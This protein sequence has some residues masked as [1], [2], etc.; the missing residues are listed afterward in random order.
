MPLRIFKVTKDQSLK[1]S[2]D[3]GS[4]GDDHAPVGKHQSQADVF[5]Q[6]WDFD[7]DWTGMTRLRGAWLVAK[8]TGEVHLAFGGSPRVVVSYLDAAFRTGGGAENSWSASAPE[9]YP[10]PARSGSAEDSVTTAQGKRVRVSIIGLMEAVAPASVKRRNGTPC[11]GARLFGLAVSSA[12]PTSSSRS[13]EFYG[14][15]AGAANRPYIEVEYDDNE[16]PRAPLAETL[17]PLTE[18]DAS[19][20]GYP[21]RTVETTGPL[22]VVHMELDDPDLP[23]PDPRPLVLPPGSAKTDHITRW[24]IEVYQA[25]ATDAT[26]DAGTAVR[27]AKATGSVS[28]TVTREVDPSMALDEDLMNV[29]VQWRG[30]LYDKRGEQGPWCPLQKVRLNRPPK[31]PTAVFADPGSQDPTVTGVLLDDDAGS[32]LA[33]TQSVRTTWS[34]RDPATGLVTVKE[35]RWHDTAGGTAFSVATSP[36]LDWDREYRLFVQVRDQFGSV[37]PA[38]GEPGAMPYTLVTPRQVLGPDDMTPRS[39]ATRLL[40]RTPTLTIGHSVAFDQHELLAYETVDERG[41]PTGAPSWTVPVTSNTSG[42]TVAKVWAGAARAWGQTFWWMAR[43]HITGGAWTPWSRAYPVY[44]DAMPSGS[45]VYH[46]QAD[47]TLRLVTEHVELVTETLR[48]QFVIPFTDPDIGDTPRWRR[49]EV[50]AALDNALILGSLVPLQARADVVDPCRLLAMEAYEGASGAVGG[51]TENPAAGEM[52]L[53]LDTARWEQGLASLRMALTAF[54]IST[55]AIAQSPPLTLGTLYTDLSSALITRFLVDVRITGYHAAGGPTVRLRWVFATS[56]DFVEYDI[57]PGSAPDFQT[58]TMMKADVATAAPYPVAIGGTVDWSKVTAVQLRVANNAA[59]VYTGDVHLDN[60]VVDPLWVLGEHYRM[61]SAY[62]DDNAE[63][64][65]GVETTVPIKAS[66]SPT[67]TWAGFPSPTDPTPTLPVRY[68][69]EVPMA[70]HRVVIH[71]RRGYANLI[72][73][74]PDMASHWRL[75]EATG[76]LGDS[77]RGRGAEAKGTVT[78]QVTGPLTAVEPSDTAVVLDGATGYL[79]MGDQH[80]F[81]GGIGGQTPY[82]VSLFY[83]DD[84]VDGVP[85]AIVQKLDAGVAPSGWSL[86]RDATGGIRGRRY[87]T[88]AGVVA[89]RGALGHWR[90][91]DPATPVTRYQDRV[92]QLVPASYWRMG[93]AAAGAYHLTAAGM[94][95]AS[96]WR[97]GEA[98]GTFANDGSTSTVLTAVGG[99][100]HDVAGAPAPVVDDGAVELDGTTGYLTG[101]D[102]HGFHGNAPFSLAAWVLIDVSA[103]AKVIIAKSNGATN[104]YRFMVETTNAITLFRF[105]SGTAQGVSSAVV[106]TGVWHLAVATYDGATLKLFVDNVLTSAASAVAIGATTEVFTVGRNSNAATSFFDGRL[107]EVLVWSRALSDEEAGSLYRALAVDEMGVVNARV[108][109]TVTRDIAGALPAPDDDGAIDF[110]G[111]SGYLSAG[112]NYQFPNNEPFSWAAWIRPDVWDASARRVIGNGDGAAGYMM[113]LMSTGKVAV[114]RYESGALHDTVTSVATCPTGQWTHVAVTYDGATLA[115]YVGTAAVVTAASSRPMLAHAT[116][117]KIGRSGGAAAAWWDGGIDEAS[118][119]TRAL[120]AAEVQWLIAPA[121]LDSVGT[122]HGSVWGTVTRD[123]AG[124]LA[125][126]NDGGIDLDGTSGYV[127][128]SDAP[129]DFDGVKPFSIAIWVRPDALS[130]ARRLIDKAYWSLTLTGATGKVRFQRKDIAAAADDLDSVA[131]LTTG[132]WHLV[133]ATY[134]GATMRLYV[135][136]AAPVSMAS[137]RSLPVT[138]YRV[139]VGRQTAAAAAYWDGRVDE[140]TIWPRAISDAEVAELRTVAALAD[141]TDSTP[142]TAPIVQGQTYH[143]ALTYDGTVQRIHLDGVL[144]ATGAATTHPLG[145]T[146]A[147]LHVG[148]SSWGADFAQALVDEVVIWEGRAPTEDEVLAHFEERLVAPTE[149]QT[150]PDDQSLVGDWVDT[151]AASGDLV[152]LPV[153]VGLLVDNGAWRAEVDIEDADGL[154]VTIGARAS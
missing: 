136:D 60:L 85:Q 64:A 95:P 37:S 96:W 61:T 67:P 47:G 132:A 129:F 98:S 135:D 124:A 89:G 17:S 3:G 138:S 93:E 32:L 10:G 148:R 43:V 48:P 104:G 13:T 142:A 15:R 126:D 154:R 52:V 114:R 117:L 116:T 1:T 125:A 62:M 119:F 81:D 87:Y 63:S 35:S 51:W 134:D 145:I 26:A 143:V 110:D 31:S 150:D 30:R 140:L 54:P 123:A 40:T 99:V 139:T 137:T 147:P 127:E 108:A 2:P 128:L 14:M 42:L 141:P 115:L 100:T 12:D 50:R 41:E 39:T 18:T 45:P 6:L 74:S 28:G 56:A 105:G 80:S 84:R 4:G 152:L 73:A 22:L 25:D 34:Y 57:A 82:G 133:T 75:G 38:E 131:V 72:G 149:S 102:I 65:W 11:G 122:A 153:P 70:R 66:R 71:R 19:A 27:F 16:P 109:G 86:D 107:D 113:W 8:T 49:L 101:G 7:D 120:T 68:W 77:G 23:I 24:D 5:R 55:T 83:R 92:A 76:F 111:T 79:E 130:D 118:V 91:G 44:I 20:P 29:G 21:Y 58:R 94:V 88:Y 69:G 121:A 36:G 112:V 78:R 53:S 106:S 90:M 46:Q 9:V 146:D 103:N 151:V 144:A 97:L 33:A 59:G